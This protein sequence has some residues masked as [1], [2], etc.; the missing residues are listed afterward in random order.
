MLN[1]DYK[2][3]SRVLA[4]RLLKVI[5]AV[6]ARDQTCG[7]PGRYIGENISF[8]C[9]VVHYASSSDIPVVILSID[10]EKAFDRVDWS[11]LCRTLCEMGFGPSFVQWADL[12][13]WGVQSAVNVNGHLS[14]FFFLSRGV[15]QGCPLSP[16][17]YVLYSEVLACNIQ[18]NPSISGLSL[19][20]FPSPLPVISQYA[21]DMNLVVTSDQ[22]IKAVFDSYSLFEKGS[23]SRLNLGKSKGLWLGSLRDR[24]DPPVDLQWSLDKIKVLGIFIGPAASHEDNWRPR[25]SAVEKV[26]LSWRQQSLSLQDRA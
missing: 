17:L 26:L 10:Q 19:P 25:I 18:A 1:V 8:L 11:F 9:D 2:I 6:V 4:G 20:G 24:R 12:L 3:A 5:Q 7:V 21:D 23:G 13:Y 16:Q 14:S 15:R 22:P